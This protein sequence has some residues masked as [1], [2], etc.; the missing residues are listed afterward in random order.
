MKLWRVD[1]NN[2]L[3]PIYCNLKCPELHW[4]W[5]II[6]SLQVCPSEILAWVNAPF[7]LKAHVLCVWCMFVYVSVCTYL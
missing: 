1:S 6:F 5:C 2:R 7:L 4:H 3:Q